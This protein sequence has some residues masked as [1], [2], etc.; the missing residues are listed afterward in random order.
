ME[1]EEGDFALF[2]E[3][4]GFRPP[5]PPTSDVVFER[6]P[7]N[8]LP[9]SPSKLTVRLVGKHSLWAHRLWNAGVSLAK[10]LDKNKSIYNG[11]SVL[12]LG[13]AAAL[14]SFVCALNGADRVVITDYPD[15]ELMNNIQFNTANL[16]P[17]LI[18]TEHISIQGHL[19]GEDATPLLAA[20]KTPKFH[21]L[22]LADLIFNHNQHRQLLRTIVN[23]L[24]PTPASSAP[25]DRS[26]AYCIYSHHVPK[27][28]DRDL[29][30]FELA[31]LEEYGLEVEHV[32]DETWS[33][34][35]PDDNGDIVKR[36]TVYCWRLWLPEK[37]N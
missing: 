19:W 15:P 25:E 20:L 12:E 28:A 31:T 16:L 7:E 18:N 5:P 4:E 13:A 8:I 2:E 10:Y 9:G 37:P 34:M 24:Q 6:D 36:S 32:Y 17:D 3:P 30:F 11:K 21:L 29:A 33:P 27:W 26:Y 14:P 23:C 22:I 1:L 35:F